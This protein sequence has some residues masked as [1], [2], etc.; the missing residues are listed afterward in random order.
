M[1]GRNLFYIIGYIAGVFILLLGAVFYRQ[2]LITV[3]ILLMLLLPVISIALTRAA[4]K[5]LSIEVIMPEGE[6]YLPCDMNITVR[7]HNRS[8][9]PLLNCELDFRFRNL[10]FPEPPVQELI[11][12]AEAKS[13]HDFKLPFSVG[14]AGMFD[15]SVESVFVTDY[16][17]FYSCRLPFTFHRELPIL[18]QKCELPPLNLTKA[19]IESDES[20]TSEEGEL[21]RDIKQLREYRPGDRIKD[22]HWKMTAKTDDV[23]VK[24]YERSKDLY[25][26]ILPEL[27]TNYLQKGL[28]VFYSLGLKLIKE[29]ETFRVAVYHPGDKS[30]D[31]FRVSDEED[32]LQAV[33]RLYLEPVEKI[34]T[35]MESFDNQYPDM[36]GLIRISNGALMMPDAPEIY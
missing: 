23:S 10:F 3:L 18:P 28:S 8:I 22:I 33:Y 25:Y 34:S 36:Q 9:F 30:F 7:L 24:E 20:E 13:R 14:A 32:L 26:L 27:D 4:M 6:L 1:R 12:P 5:K 11:L 21:T 2:P 19:L 16:L 15:F 29:R 31:M 17:H 35:A